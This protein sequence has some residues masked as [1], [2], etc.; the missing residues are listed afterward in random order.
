MK[1]SYDVVVIGSGFGG[2]ITACR[3]SQAGRSVCILERGRQWDKTD[4][5][6]SPAEVSKSFWRKGKSLG[7][8][9]YK[10]F[11]RIDV[12]QGCGVGG[13]SLHYFNV[14]LRTPAGIFSLPNWPGSIS[15]E[16]MDPY[17]GV[18]EDMLDSEKLNPPEGRE[19]PARTQ[20]F[21]RAA[22]AAG[23]DP[24]LVPIGVYTGVDRLNPHS[25]IPQSACDYSGNCMLGCAVHSKGTLD[26]NYI[27]VAKRNGAELFP[28]HEVSR[29]DSLGDQGYRVHFDRIDP[30]Q[31]GSRE[32]GSVIGKKI[33]VAAGTLGSNELLL[34]CRDQYKSLPDLSPLLGSRFSGNGDFL[35]AATVGADAEVDPARGPSITAGAEFSTRNNKI[36]IE[37]LG[38]PDP[39]IWM[40]EGMIPNRNRLGNLLQAGKSYLLDS[41][42]I[43]TG[44]IDFEADRLFRGGATTRLLPYLGMGTDA[45]D[46]RLRLKS[47]SVDIDWSHRRSRQM[48][49]EMEEAMESLSRGINGKYVSSVLWSWPFRKLVTAHP[50]GGCFMGDGRDSSVVNDRGEVWGYPGLYVADGAIIPTALSVN[51][52]LTIS[53]LAERVAFQLIHDREMTP[54]DPQTPKN[55]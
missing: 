6:R 12:V 34:R 10:A 13:G 23:R 5:P 4:F 39:F 20:A 27:P 25:G 31:P 7:F 37:D 38:F 43:G 55:Q 18:A 11:K 28:L 45:A 49:W 9:E 24:E 41:L 33:V 22:K 48:F 17:Y 32:P 19:L 36:Y 16:V 21:M 3:L 40:L 8:L 50:L 54:G 29:L 14:H 26:L 44:K 35:L 1:E 2:A 51:P 42:G 53:A 15:R 52:S 47:G 30:D 46:G